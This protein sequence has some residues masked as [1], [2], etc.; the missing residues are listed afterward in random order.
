MGTAKDMLR[1]VV[2]RTAGNTR[3]IGPLG[4][5]G[6]RGRL[7]EWLWRSWPVYG[8]Y[9][10]E[11]SDGRSL[12]IRGA[13]NDWLEKVH[14]FK[15]PY[16]SEV[17]TLPVFMKL[18]ARSGLI[19]D[20]G[21][22]IGIFT[23][24]ACLSGPQVRVISFEP[25]PEVFSRLRGNV[26]ANGWSDRCELRN[27]AASDRRGSAVFDLYGK[28][29]SFGGG[30][31]PLRVG[32]RPSEKENLIEVKTDTVD[33]ACAGKGRVGLAKIDV[34]G[35]EDAVL[36][37][38]AGVL[39]ESRP[40]LI[41]ECLEEGPYREVMGILLPLG[42]RI[43]HLRRSGLQEVDEVRPD[44]RRQERNFLFTCDRDLPACLA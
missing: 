40:D 3:F 21:A 27:E 19:L 33:A 22:N 8:D 28:R 35:H 6:R 15:G 12:R 36:R 20:I 25:S 4:R 23:L 26:E 34:E 32:R 10:L 2:K 16:G 39:E 7:P 42:Y 14:F 31:Y 30:I 24:L 38:M 17:E 5:L 44:P 1:P 43:Y 41:V 37:G 18:A 11:L 13:V 9:D 29:S